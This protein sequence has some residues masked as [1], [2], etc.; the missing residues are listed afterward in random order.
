[1]QGRLALGVI[2]LVAGKQPVDPARE[3]D[4]RH[5]RQQLLQHLLVDALARD[6]EVIGAL[7]TGE[8]TGSRRVGSK[9]GPQMYVAAGRGQ[10]LQGSP[11]RQGVYVTGFHGDDWSGIVVVE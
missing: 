9:Q 4:S 2:D 10:R 8:T 5:Q 7:P 1:M 11:L 6:I 3:V